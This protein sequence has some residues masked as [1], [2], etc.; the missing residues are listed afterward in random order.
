MKAISTFLVIVW[1]AI[2]GAQ[3]TTAPLTIAWQAPLSSS[4]YFTTFAANELPSLDGIGANVP[5][6][7]V[8]DCTSGG[9]SAPCTN[10]QDIHDVCDPTMGYYNWCTVDTDLLAYINGGYMSG[11]KIVLILQ[12]ENAVPANSNT[13]T[14]GYV[15][16]QNWANTAASQAG[17]T[18]TTCP[19][20]DVSVC[21]AWQGDSTSPVVG[22]FTA[23]NGAIWNASAN[24]CHFVGSGLSCPSHSA[25][26]DFSGFPVV[27]ETPLIIAYQNLLASMATHYNISTGSPNGKKIA[28]Y[29]AYVRVG[30]AAGGEN[31][32]QC[33][34]TGV[35][36]GAPWTASQVV[37]AGYVVQ[38]P[39]AVNAGNYQFVS[40][41]SG[42]T[43]PTSSSQP[44]WCQNP[45]CYTSADGSITR[46]HNV[47]VLTGS[48]G[49]AIWPGPEGQ[50]QLNDY[51]DNGYLSTWSLNTPTA[52]DGL[53]YVASMASFLSSLN[54]SFSWDTS[55][56]FGPPFNQS[57]AYADAEAT[58]AALNGVG[59]GQQALNV[60]DAMTLA[61]GAYP[62]G[63]NDWIG[64]FSKYPRTPVR[65]LQLAASGQGTW[66]PAYQ[67]G[68]SGASGIV[69][70]NVSGTLVA[71]VNCVDGSGSPLTCPFAGGPIF[72]TG[73][74]NPSLNAGWNPC[75]GSVCSGGVQFI[76]P[77][78]IATGTYYGGTLWSPSFW[79]VTMPFAVQHGATSI[80]IWECDLDYAFGFTT[81]NSGMG[82]CDPYPDGIS[83]PDLNL[84]AILSNTRSGT[85]TQSGVHN[86]TTSGHTIQF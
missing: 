69:I 75:T 27:Y 2:G 81:S 47:G 82:G 63:I 8:D 19:L 42:T 84:Q 24:S 67:I 77:T 35:I 60:G 48:N 13:F 33:V 54:A 55:S 78:G 1:S 59:F 29:I 21:S 61:S 52:S 11:K 17:K 25:N 15:F 65:H 12:P 57:L 9:T 18:C 32:P 36:S 46:W 41:S 53:G 34:M 50:G 66:W 40:D 23:S 49:S 16:T 6:F 3:T 83:G 56:H 86:G 62:S 31:T 43:A 72:I 26:T 70:S 80:E 79:L 68:A 85:P 10:G 28:P 64:N 20:Q 37:P 38:P 73:N 30:L 71:T 39:N 7:I 4:P 76:V 51:V 74:A 44:T 14:P 5:W 22:T 45:G 58:L